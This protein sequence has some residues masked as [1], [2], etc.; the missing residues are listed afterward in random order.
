MGSKHF[1]LFLSFL[2]L[3]NSP[4]FGKPAVY[5]DYS[6]GGELLLKSGD[7]E[8]HQR[9]GHFKNAESIFKA[10]PQALKFYQE[11]EE[12]IDNMWLSFWLITGLYL[13]GT[14]G[15][16]IANSSNSQAFTTDFLFLTAG[17]IFA[18][19]F[20]TGHFAFKAQA[21]FLKALNTMNGVYAGN[22]KEEEEGLALRMAAVPTKDGGS[23]AL[24]MDF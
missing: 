12:N 7:L 9:F 4:A 8:L 17:Y 10:N 23:F 21:N 15:L 24:S 13:G 5:L 3:V 18:N 2:I 1:V 14:V 20:S 16:G 11:S 6:D 22:K 19:T